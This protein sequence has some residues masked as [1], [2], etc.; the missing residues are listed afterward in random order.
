MTGRDGLAGDL[1]ILMPLWE[2]PADRV[3]ADLDATRLLLRVSDRAAA[4]ALLRSAGVSPALVDTTLDDPRRVR[5]TTAASP[6]GTW[7]GV[8]TSGALFSSADDMTDPKTGRP[9]RWEQLRSA[10]TR[11][12][13]VE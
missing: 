10:A 13:W 2:I 5:W 3:D 7:Y 4:T 1:R 12:G 6:A 11:A 9:Y 8:R